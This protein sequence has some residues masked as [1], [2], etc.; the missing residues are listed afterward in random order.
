M[1]NKVIAGDY[2]GQIV[3]LRKGRMFIGNTEINKATVA[4]YEIMDENSSTQSFTK[5]NTKKSM[6]GAGTK[7][8]V[9]AAI[10]TAIAPGIGTL[11]GAAAG[12]TTSKAKNKSVTTEVTKKELLVAVYFANG[13]QSLLQLD[14]IGYKNFLRATFADP[15]QLK[16]KEQKET[17][18]KSLTL[19][20]LGWFFIPYI[21]IFVFWKKL[22]QTNKILGVIWSIIALT[23]IIHGQ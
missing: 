16:L 7:G 21:M 9:G 1:T 13:E 5:G 12:V 6:I 14:N 20:V 18:N 8:A 17:K 10:G 4:E 19:K 11:I 23:V 15:A 2:E 22:S 3:K